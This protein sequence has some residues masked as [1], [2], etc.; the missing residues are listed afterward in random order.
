M[1]SNTAWPSGKPTSS[2]S[3]LADA[4]ALAWLLKV[5]PVTVRMWAVRGLI[6]RAGSDHRGR[7][8]YDV[9][10]V[11]R[12]AATRGYGPACTTP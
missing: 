6:E 3:K 11:L 8:V 4:T 10:E 9:D 1:T 7:T 5:K 12:F 2:V